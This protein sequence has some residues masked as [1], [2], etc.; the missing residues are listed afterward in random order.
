MRKI[1]LFLLIKASAKGFLVL[2]NFYFSEIF[3]QGSHYDVKRPEK[4]KNDRN[5]QK[6]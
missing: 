6:Q 2:K 4:K 5:Y 1:N 3:L